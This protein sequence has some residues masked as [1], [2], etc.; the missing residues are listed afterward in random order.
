VVDQGLQ[1]AEETGE[2]CWLAELHRLRGELLLR[3]GEDHDGAEESF[4]QAI[5]TARGQGSKAWELRAATSLGRLMHHQG[6][7]G[8][9]LAAVQ[10]VY[11]WFAEG[12][13][14]IDL[15]GAKALLDSLA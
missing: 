6:R 4:R 9:A 14:T 12:S 13:D 11:E 3:R 1:R 15:R 7:T 10:P 8:E 2:R 5:E